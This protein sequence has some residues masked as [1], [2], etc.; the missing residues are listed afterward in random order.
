MTSVALQNARELA[1]LSRSV[2]RGLWDYVPGA[3]P[4]W[5][6]GWHCHDETSDW[7]TRSG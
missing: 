5:T 6:A 2:A 7:C 1:G 4:T 3:M